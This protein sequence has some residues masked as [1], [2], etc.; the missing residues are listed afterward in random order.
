MPTP[1]AKQYIMWALSYGWI[2][3]TG[4]VLR[5]QENAVMQTCVGATAGLAFS[6]GFGSYLIAMDHQSF[7]NLGSTKGNYA[8]VS[9]PFRTLGKG[10][11]ALL[12][13]LRGLSNPIA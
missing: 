4:Y 10:R 3:L 7:L 6:G 2:R 9:A 5:L 11:T 12:S 8:S 13:H 1:P